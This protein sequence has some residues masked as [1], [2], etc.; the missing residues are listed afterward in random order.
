MKKRILGWLWL[1]LLAMP[2]S[3]EWYRGNLHCH[4]HWSDG[5]ALPEY[6]VQFYKENGYHF[7]CLS[8]HNLFQSEKLNIREIFGYTFPETDAKAFEGETSTWKPV[9][10]SGWARLTP[11]QVE[12]TA[13]VCGKDSIISKQVGEKTY[14]RLKTFTELEKQFSEPGRFL[15]IPGYEQTGGCPDGRQVH[16]NFI[17]V[18]EP[19][20][21][22]KENQT[23]TEMIRQTEAKGKELY[24]NL[25]EGY[26]FIVNHPSWR[27]YDISPEAL[28]E[29]SHIRF[30]EIVNNSLTFPPNEKGWTPE[31][32]WDAV[33]AYRATHGQ[34]LLLGIGSDD[35]HGYNGQPPSGCMYVQADSLTI[36]AL[37]EAIRKGD[38][39]ASLGIELEKV[40]FDAATK[41][42]HVQ[43][44]AE[45]GVSYRIDFIGTKKG[46]AEKHEVIEVPAVEKTPARKIDVYSD[47]VGVV[48][49]SI[50]GVEASYTLQ[51]DDLYVRA[52]V[53]IPEKSKIGE[54]SLLLR[55]CAWTQPV[56]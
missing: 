28:K 56:R 5:N 55:P 50:D 39:Y 44:K 1:I 29:L 19:F 24:G 49:K 30:F 54:R 32:F 21:Y 11:Q 7:L 8:D 35:R 40:D 10:G 6:V 36:P 13:N 31:K 42:L 27:Y 47:E 53:F 22:L 3:G 9:D 16:M 48:L 34:E 14:V 18:R 38:F 12:Q 25:P 43:V 33:N 37:F 41:T 23:P 52:R 15:M 51:E 46:Y 17:N 20:A 26:L 45:E 2:A 4:S